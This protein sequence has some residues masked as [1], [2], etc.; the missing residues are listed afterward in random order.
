MARRQQLGQP[1]VLLLQYMNGP[2]H[3]GAVIVEAGIAP[4]AC[5]V[6]VELA[7]LFINV[8]GELEL[9]SLDVDGVGDGG[10]VVGGAVLLLV[11]RLQEG[12][13]PCVLLQ[14]CQDLQ[15]C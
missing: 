6:G 1:K 7:G 3:K 8:V 13:D 4:H 15:L 12:S 10:V 14:F 5:E 2:A 11:H 9:D